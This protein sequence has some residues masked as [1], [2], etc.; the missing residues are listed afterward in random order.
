MSHFRRYISLRPYKAWRDLQAL[1]HVLRFQSWLV[2]LIWMVQLAV[3]PYMSVVGT[4]GVVVV[5]GTQ[6][7]IEVV[8]RWVVLVGLVAVVFPERGVFQKGSICRLIEVQLVGIFDCP[9]G[10]K[11]GIVAW[12]VR[13]IV[14]W[15]AEVMVTAVWMVI[16]LCLEVELMVELIVLVLVIRIF[17]IRIGTELLATNNL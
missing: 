13:E 1:F 4:V 2:Q 11:M 7:P 6:G 17:V 5:W 14:A 10:E 15:L 16:F 3:F 8:V 12:L 9:G